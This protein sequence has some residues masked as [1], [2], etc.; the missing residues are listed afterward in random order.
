M[1]LPKIFTPKSRH[2]K[3][4]CSKSVLKVSNIML[5]LPACNGIDA[6]WVAL[7]MFV[8]HFATLSLPKTVQYLDLS[9]FVNLVRN[10]SEL[11]Q[12][13]RALIKLSPSAA[14]GMVRIQCI[15]DIEPRASVRLELGSNHSIMPSAWLYLRSQRPIVLL[16]AQDDSTAK[17]RALHQ[18]SS[19]TIL[20]PKRR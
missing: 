9:I 15:R 14:R 12:K 18:C 20:W 7:I 5:H 2:S 16:A 3:S 13:H 17:T 11:H 19:Y 4:C 10:L 1:K 6:S 8:R